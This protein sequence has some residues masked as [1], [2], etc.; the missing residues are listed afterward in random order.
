MDTVR[1]RK[2]EPWEWWNNFRTLCEN[3][4]H[5]GVGMLSP[6]FSLFFCPLIPLFTSSYLISSFV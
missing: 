1:G 2:N 4:P 3:G 5:L 6:P